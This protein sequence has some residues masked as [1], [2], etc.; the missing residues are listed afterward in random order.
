MNYDMWSDLF[1]I[2]CIGYGVADHLQPRNEKNPIKDETECDRLDSIVKSWIYGTLSLSLLHTILKK[3]ASTYQV[4]NTI[5]KVFRD[6]KDSKIIQ[7][8]NE[9]HNVSNGDSSIIDYCN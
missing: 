6:N 4:W 8:D 1:E 3:K 7:H 9:I 2:H 5:K